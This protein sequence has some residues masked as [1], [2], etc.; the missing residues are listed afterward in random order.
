[1][2][3]SLTELVVVAG[4]SDDFSFKTSLK[5]ATRRHKTLAKN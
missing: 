4:L 1:M 3:S 2:V 5:A